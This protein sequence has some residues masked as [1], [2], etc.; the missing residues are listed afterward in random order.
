MGATIHTSRAAYEGAVYQRQRPS[1]GHIAPTPSTH[2]AGP[3]LRSGRFAV[4]APR[5]YGKWTSKVLSLLPALRAGMRDRALDEK[6][7]SRVERSRI[8]SASEATREAGRLDG[9]H[10]SGTRT[11]SGINA[12]LRRAYRRDP[13][14][15]ASRCVLPNGR[16]DSGAPRAST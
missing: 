15:G 7:P 16:R 9:E 10:G 1:A 11:D 6:R 13:S 4:T 8:A 14:S 3:P 2:Y 5:R 12:D